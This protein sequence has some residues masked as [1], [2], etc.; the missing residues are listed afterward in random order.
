MLGEWL[1]QRSILYPEKALKFKIWTIVEHNHPSTSKY[2]VDELV[3]RAGYEVVR[4]PVAH[5]ELN[6]IEMA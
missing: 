1:E 5:S 3:S 6:P 2:V 4:L